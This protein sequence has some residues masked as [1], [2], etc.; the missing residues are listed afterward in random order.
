MNPKA[1]VVGAVNSIMHPDPSIIK[2]IGL[3]QIWL[4]LPSLIRAVLDVENFLLNIFSYA[5]IDTQ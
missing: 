4:K 2:K 1:L 3:L 5:K